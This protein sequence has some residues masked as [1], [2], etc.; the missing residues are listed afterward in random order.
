MDEIKNY[1]IEEINRNELMSNMHKKDGK[2]LNYI[3]NLLIVISTISGCVSISVFCFF[4][5][6]S[7]RNYKFCNWITNL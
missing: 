7:N 5:W 3:D 1:L 4:S 6:Y 2:V